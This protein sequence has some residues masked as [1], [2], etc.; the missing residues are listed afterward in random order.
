MIGK[1]YLEYRKRVP[2]FIP[3]LKVGL[4]ND[5][6]ATSKNCSIRAK[7]QGLQIRIYI[8]IIKTEQEVATAS[9]WN[10]RIRKKAE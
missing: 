4:K 3:R 10:Y 8:S 1:E 2:M 6:Q 5:Q 9:F 7:S